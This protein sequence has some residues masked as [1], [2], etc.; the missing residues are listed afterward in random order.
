[1]IKCNLKNKLISWSRIE[2]KVW[3]RTEIEHSLKNIIHNVKL[4]IKLGMHWKYYVLS[5][6]YWMHKMISII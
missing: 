6:W 1:M 2:E 5:T 4:K 3:K